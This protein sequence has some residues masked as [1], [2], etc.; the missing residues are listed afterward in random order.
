MAVTGRKSIRLLCL[1]FALYLA[2]SL[3]A[4]QP[5]DILNQISY[6]ATALTAGNPSDAMTPFDKSYKDYDR[7]RNYFSGLTDGFQLE[8]E[9]SIGDEED[10]PTESKVTIN[11]TLTLTDPNTSYIEQR[12]AEITARLI[13]KNGNW[14]IVAFSPIEIFN[15]QQRR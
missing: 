1:A 2:T 15:P 6:I 7:L 11:W 4:D 14:K 10:K 13:K 8:N 12:T 3:S 9:V 5:H